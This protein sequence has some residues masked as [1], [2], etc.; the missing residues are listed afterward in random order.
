MIAVPFDA[1]P[2]VE[3]RQQQE[4]CFYPF[5]G[6]PCCFIFLLLVQRGILVLHILSNNFFPRILFPSSHPKSYEVVSP[7][8]FDFHFHN[9]SCTYLKMALVNMYSSA[10]KPFL[11]LFISLPN[12]TE[13]Q[14]S[15]FEILATENPDNYSFTH[16]L[17]EAPNRNIKI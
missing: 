4:S 13:S 12:W 8:D 3:V 16:V 6:L 11:F 1:H 5:K 9:N 14:S 7:C 10:S 17:W 15:V 2:E